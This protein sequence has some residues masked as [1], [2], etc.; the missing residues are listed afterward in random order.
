MAKD[1]PYWNKDL[2]CE[3]LS[4]T[5]D[6]VDKAGCIFLPAGQC[7]DMSAAIRMFKA[8]CPSIVEIK[9]VSGLVEDTVYHRI[10]GHW[11]AYEV[12]TK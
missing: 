3:V 6:F 12:R 4:L 10:S 9:M 7:C 2:G 1:L 11:I 8:I 5:V